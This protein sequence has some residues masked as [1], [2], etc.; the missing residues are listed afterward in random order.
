L[1]LKDVRRKGHL[2]RKNEN[3]YWLDKDGSASPAKANRGAKGRRRFG[4]RA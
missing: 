2:V 3:G 4:P 1:Y